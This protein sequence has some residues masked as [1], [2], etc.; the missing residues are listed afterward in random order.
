MSVESASTVRGHISEIKELLG[1][2]TGQVGDLSGKWE[3][4]SYDALV[5]KSE[6]FVTE[7]NKLETGM[8]AFAVACETYKAYEENEKSI[9]ELQTKLNEVRNAKEYDGQ[10]KAISDIKANID[11][12]EKANEEYAKTI[13]AQLST[14][15]GS[16]IE[17]PK[18]FSI[19]DGAVSIGSS[20]S[21]I[22][23]GSGKFTTKKIN[24]KEATYLSFNENAIFNQ[25]GH[26]GSAQC[27]VYSV[28]YGW[29]ILEGKS[30][31]NGNASHQDV[32]NAY[33]SGA[34]CMT[35]WNNMNS[36]HCNSSKER[37]NAIWDEVMGNKKPCVVA[38]GSNTA[39]NHYVL[40]TGVRSGATK[41]NLK[42]SDLVVLDPA[43]NGE[44]ILHYYDGG[45]F[46]GSGYGLQMATFNT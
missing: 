25:L 2:Y 34:F 29:T 14:A 5:K 32:A 40:V 22:D 24:G 42:P 30:R 20:G 9:K 11:E 26:Q 4:D 19:M 13:K 36:F 1:N 35:Q 16:K 38:V 12:L 8:E 18:S 3:G 17:G 31:I 7:C 41:A 44:N 39:S 6:S 28:A 15:A 46:N 45:N 43:R 37:M 27:G 33:N 21:G 23:L 10:Q